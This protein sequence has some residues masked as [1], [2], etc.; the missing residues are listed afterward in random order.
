MHNCDGLYIILTQNSPTTF[1]IAIKTNPNEPLV[2]C[3][4]S[5]LKLCNDSGIVPVAPTIN[6][7]RPPNTITGSSSRRLR[8]QGAGVVS[9]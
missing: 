4:T 1:V 9:K 8:N 2:L 7:G 3:H 5:D 6:H